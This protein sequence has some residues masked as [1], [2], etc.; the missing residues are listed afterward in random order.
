MPEEQQMVVLRN[1]GA[2]F[3]ATADRHFYFGTSSA[4]VN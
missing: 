4:A 3:H 2:E 1:D